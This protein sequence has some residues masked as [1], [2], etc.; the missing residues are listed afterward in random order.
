MIHVQVT[1]RSLYEVR[2]RP[3]KTYS[4]KVFIMSNVIAEI[5]WS[6]MFP[7]ILSFLLPKITLTPLCPTVL[8]G[9]VIYFTWY[10]PIGYYRNAIP[11]DAVHLRGALMFL[12]IE[13][14]MLFTSTFAIMI[15]AGIDTAETAGN[16]ANLLF[17]MCLIFCGWVFFLWPVFAPPHLER[18]LIWPLLHD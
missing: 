5:P 9:V 7:Q 3:S 13:M 1:Q 4:W 14:F 15:V 17:L 8:M 10:Y 16:I 2:E 12:Y 18:L 11:T 6:S